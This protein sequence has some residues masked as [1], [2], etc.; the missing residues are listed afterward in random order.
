MNPL[1]QLGK[2]LA[3]LNKASNNAE[4]NNPSVNINRENLRES[5]IES[6]LFNGSINTSKIE[7]EAVRSGGTE[8]ENVIGAQKYK[9]AAGNVA[10][11]L[12]VSPV[13]EPIK[14]LGRAG[15]AT[16]ALAGHLLKNAEKATSALS[17]KEAGQQ[18]RFSEKYE[19]AIDY[20]KDQ[21]GKA[22][23]SALN[24]VATPLKA[25]AGGAAITATATKEGG[26]AIGRKAAQAWEATE[27]AR[28]TA[29]AGAKILAAGTG[30]LVAVAAG[31]ALS[32]IALGMAVAVPAASSTINVIGS[33][34]AGAVGGAQRGLEKQGKSVIGQA[35]KG[36]AKGFVKGVQ[37]V[38]QATNL[39]LDKSEEANAGKTRGEKIADFFKNNAKRYANIVTSPKNI[40]KNY[41]EIK[42]K[43]T[44]LDKLKEDIAHRGEQEKIRYDLLKDFVQKGKG[45]ETEEL[46]AINK[47][48]DDRSKEN[49]IT[50]VEQVAAV[51]KFA[52]AMQEQAR[53][54]MEQNRVKA[55]LEGA[56]NIS[57]PEA[58]EISVA[59]STNE[60]HPTTSATEQKRPG[61]LSRI[62]QKFK[63]ENGTSTASGVLETSTEVENTAAATAE[64]K[65]F[66]SR[67]R[68]NK[69]ET[70]SPEV[71]SQAS[72]EFASQLETSTNNKPSIIRQMSDMSEQSSTIAANKD[73]A[74]SLERS[75]S[76]GDQNADESY[77]NSNLSS[78]EK[79]LPYVPT[80]GFAAK[81]NSRSESQAD[82]IK[83]EQSKR[84][85]AVAS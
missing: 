40:G 11:G 29:L 65:G 49:A 35:I 16:T 64:K 85:L 68:R 74:N 67:F 37:T 31:L 61:L 46:Y 77:T 3:A 41:S 52:V 60:Q 58:D 50:S 73:T 17:E 48:N 72:Q 82:A 57:T 6:N 10:A 34:A 51:K 53:R 79:K 63:K 13:V 84:E 43:K 45:I 78:L 70:Q 80:G 81:I 36:A 30:G 15:I 18:E 55:I 12:V 5:Y 21:Y 4:A 7:R 14:A 25:V 66:F 28:S 26:Q 75:N 39:E 42:N 2:A 71:A 20:A 32:P 27:G 9:N 38:G 62:R 1:K 83:E 47:L 54:R 44:S 22:A 19:T 56:D 8:Q 23:K 69:A 59:T 24:T 33:T 76:T